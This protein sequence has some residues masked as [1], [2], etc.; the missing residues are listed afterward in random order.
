MDKS[1][2]KRHLVMWIVLAALVLV[3]FVIASIYKPDILE[4]VN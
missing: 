3:G 2:R 1:L 4:I